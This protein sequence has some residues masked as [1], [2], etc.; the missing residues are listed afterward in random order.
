MSKMSAPDISYLYKN[1][2]LFS[3]LVIW[4]NLKNAVTTGLVIH[5]LVEG[6]MPAIT[7]S[8]IM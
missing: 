3:Y 7:Q 8:V 2:C 6:I 4:Q 1:P 5:Q